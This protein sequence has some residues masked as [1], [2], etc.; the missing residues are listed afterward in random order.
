M[1]KKAFFFDIDGLLVNS[2]LLQAEAM[3]E[4]MKKIASNH[5]VEFCPHEM[6]TEQLQELFC[7]GTEQEALEKIKSQFPMFIPHLKKLFELAWS[8]FYRKVETDERFKIITSI[9]LLKNLSD[10]GAL[11]CL[12]SNSKASDIKKYCRILQVSHLFNAN[13]FV[14]IEDVHGKGKPEPDIYLYAAKKFN[15]NPR[16]CLAFEDSPAGVAAAKKAGIRVIGLDLS[17]KHRE[18][19]LNAG[20]S[21]VV[22]NLLYSSILSSALYD[23]SDY[24][25]TLSSASIRFVTIQKISKIEIEALVDETYKIYSSNFSGRTLAQWRSKLVDEKDEQ[26]RAGFFYDNQNT[27]QGYAI[28]KIRKVIYKSET[29]YVGLVSAAVSK[30]FRGGNL[31]VTFYQV[32]FRR[33][34][35]AY[36]HCPKHVF[37]NFLGFPG[38]SLAVKV[39]NNIYPSAKHPQVDNSTLEYMQFLADYVGYKK[40]LDS[41]HPF[42]YTT[43]SRL[44]PLSEEARISLIKNPD[45]DCCFIT[46]ATELKPGHGMLAL[47]P[48][49]LSNLRPM[50]PN[51]S[52]V[53]SFTKSLSVF[54]EQS[55]Q[56]QK[57]QQ[58]TSLPLISPPSA[59]FSLSSEGLV[60]F[61][62]K[63]YADI[64]QYP[65][66]LEQ[67]YINFFRELDRFYCNSTKETWQEYVKIIRAHKLLNLVHECPFTKR[68]YKKPRGYAGDA[69]VLDYI[70]Y[71]IPENELGRVSARGQ[72]LCRITTNTPAA[73]AV[74]NRAKIIGKLVDSISSNSQQKVR[75]LSIACGHLREM[76]QSEKFMQKRVQVVALDQDSESLAVVESDYLNQDVS[77]VNARIKKLLIDPDFV[78]SLGKFDLVYA[79]GLFDY[80]DDKT[81]KQLIKVM[82]ALTKEGGVTLITNFAKGIVNQAHMDSIMDWQ[83]IY[84][85]SCELMSLLSEFSFSN[86]RLYSDRTE[87][88]LF[89]EC[90]K[91]P[92]PEI[93]AEDSPM[94]KKS[95]NEQYELRAK[96]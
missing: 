59:K 6:L 69:V 74:R 83:L 86:M 66:M 96:L 87:N 13:A 28:F 57:S 4:A 31:P 58:V 19:L 61:L 22:N 14:S 77:I 37:D 25:F 2:H 53:I 17:M 27:L 9:T 80:L 18:K 81:A 34:S 62:D 94:F 30:S 82:N 56:Q 10:I 24:N 29:R 45:P 90:K 65:E 68:I 72:E 70:Y 5:N 60:N 78:K 15:V 35:L 33:F 76:S 40:S 49:E 91:T 8:I 92:R 42:V 51:H 36:P 63:V 88:I 47:C 12:V 64:C 54:G 85:D 71:G 46:K 32:E 50:A 43:A 95:K 89:V 7:G 16:D 52:R 93:Y 3:I 20:A 67:I 38:Y 79:S 21:E 11:I 26:T 55:I 73:R 39:F 1:T 84:R 75:V 44:L 41:A 23:D 48:L